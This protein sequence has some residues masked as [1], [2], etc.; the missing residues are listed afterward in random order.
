MMWGRRMLF[1]P[2]WQG[3]NALRTRAAR[4]PAY[5][6]SATTLKPHEGVSRGTKTF[7]AAGLFLLPSTYL[8]G[9]CM[10]AARP[11]PRFHWGCAVFKRRHIGLLPFAASN[12]GERRVFKSQPSRLCKSGASLQCADKMTES[13]KLTSSA[14]SER[15]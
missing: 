13:S 9:F 2:R 12:S 4:I 6:V 15:H 11:A 10:M 5:G 1:L 8:R 14:W 7:S 3:T